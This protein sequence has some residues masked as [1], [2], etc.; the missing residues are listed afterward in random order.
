LGRKTYNKDKEFDQPQRLK[1][2]NKKLKRELARLKKELSRI[3]IDRFNN[4]KDLVEVQRSEDNML[5]KESEREN[6]MKRWICFKCKEDSL[7]LLIFNRLDGI[8]YYRRCPSCGHRTKM[9]KY[10]EGIEG[11]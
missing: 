10:K 7:R 5:Q 9:K 4:L 3:D 11:V 8:F 2:E 1:A 6:L